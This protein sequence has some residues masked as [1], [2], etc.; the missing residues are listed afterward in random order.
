V[1]TRKV[2]GSHRW[3]LVTACAMLLFFFGLWFGYTLYQRQRRKAVG[4]L[5]AST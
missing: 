4:G 1:V 5:R 3:S 2:L